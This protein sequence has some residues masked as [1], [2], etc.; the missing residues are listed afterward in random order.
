MRMKV[1]HIQGNEFSLFPFPAYHDFLSTLFLHEKITRV[2]KTS[3]F[4]GPNIT[5]RDVFYLIGSLSLF[6]PA[7]TR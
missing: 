6:D 3:K 2:L 5:G 7:I 1:Q 4:V